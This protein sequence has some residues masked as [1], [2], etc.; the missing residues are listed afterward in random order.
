MKKIDSHIPLI[1]YP[2]M[3]LVRDSYVCLNGTWDITFSFSDNIPETFNYKI[4]VPYPIEANLSLLNYHLRKGELMYYRKCFKLDHDFNKG[5]VILHFDAVDQI[6]EVYV[7]RQFVYKHVGGYLPFK[8]DITDYLKEDNE[9]IIKV[10]DD[11]NKIYPYGKQAK[12]SH[13]MWYTKTSG[14]W[15]TVWLESVRENYIQSLKI[16]TDLESVN[17][18]IFGNVKNKKLIIHTETGEIIREFKKDQI[19]I[20][21]AN[22]HLWSPNDPYLYYFDLVSDED[23]VHSYFALRTIGI[24]K[25]NKNPCL[26]LNGRPY[27][28]HG[29]L[30]QGYFHDGILTPKSYQ[31]YED[32]I[33]KLKKLGF[34]TLRKHIKIEPLYFYY[35]CDKLGM[36]VFQDFV[37]N[38]RY[39]FLR[40]TILPTLGINKLSDHRHYKK[41][42][43]EEFI[44]EA[45]ETVEL[46]YNSPSVLYYTIFN[47]GWGQ[48]EAD[49]MYDLIKNIDNSRIIDSTSGWFKQN[50]SDVESKHVYFKK[51]KI[52]PSNRPLIIS[53]FGGYA[54]KD[55]A[56]SFNKKHSYGYRFFKDLSSYQLAVK[57]LYD[58]EITPFILKGI[59]GA[60][61]TQVSDVENETN[62][63]FS[64]DRKLQKINS[65]VIDKDFNN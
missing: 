42:Q 17:I 53:E 52:Q 22:P 61:Y 60:I 5:R 46:L 56:H 12:R 41:I 27:F 49:K 3:Q 16:D 37:N 6:A 63:I 58:E 9:L 24:S 48:F 26:T 34:N 55:L 7:N 11:L 23:I 19:K 40:D 50:K 45:K 13:S 62:G 59:A 57:K 20:N 43:K 30:D 4:E 21:I 29:L 14:I 31:V 51:I 39:S 65:P 8:V 10:R 2:R 36:I 32:E 38:G 47:E 28:F 64:Y 54:Y 44:K 18:K 1:E 33:I 15:K 35:L 25:I